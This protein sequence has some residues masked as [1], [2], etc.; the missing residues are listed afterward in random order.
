MS[1][2]KLI[3][4]NPNSFWGRLLR[5]PLRLLSGRAVVPVMS[6]INRGYKWR[7]GSN[8]HGC[9]L[10]IYESDKQ[11]LM[12]LLVTQGMIAYDIG[13]NAGFYTLGLARLVGSGGRV[14]AFE[15]LAENAANILDH[16]RLNCCSNATLYQVAVSDQNGLSA[17]HV[18]KSNSTGHLG[19][20]GGIGCRL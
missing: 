10:G 9:W 2:T 15:P 8:I 19:D 17:F 16:L 11:Q 1:L 18:G 20:G 3:D 12:N 4:I 7:V 14:C 13:A 5:L 6:G